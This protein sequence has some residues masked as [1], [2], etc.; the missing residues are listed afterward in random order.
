MRGSSLARFL[1]LIPLVGSLLVVSF[2]AEAHGL[3]KRVGECRETRIT[4]ITTRWG[5]PLVDD[6]DDQSGSGSLVVFRN[7]G[8]QMSFS[9]VGGLIRSRV[10]DRVRMCLVSVPQFCP[11]GDDRGRTYRTTNLRTGESWTLPDDTRVCGGA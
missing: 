5:D 6:P 9:Q 1:V 11:R 3:P 4:Q 7:G 10:R 8:T 2:A